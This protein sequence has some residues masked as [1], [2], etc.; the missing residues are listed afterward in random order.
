MRLSRSPPHER[1]LF[2][3]GRS[4]R[5]SPVT[6]VLIVRHGR[7]AEPDDLRL[8]GPDVALLPLGSRQARALAKRLRAFT[9]TEVYTSDARRARATA[10]IIAAV[11]R[12][13]VLV[14]SRLRELD[15]GLWAGQTYAEVV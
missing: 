1:L 7:A 4:A 14:D 8:P 13:P 11:C 12:V 9:P 15:V 6:R 5:A 3:T 2:V 10:E